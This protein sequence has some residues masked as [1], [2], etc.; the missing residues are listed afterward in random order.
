MRESE[1]EFAN[2]INKTAKMWPNEITRQT[3]LVSSPFAGSLDKEINFWKDLDRKLAETKD[4]MESAPILLTKL[5]L[6][7]TSRISEQLIIEAESKLDRSIETVRASLNFIRDFP[8]AELEEANSLAKINRSIS[9]CLSH[10]AKMRHSVYDFTRAMKMLEVLGSLIISRIVVIFQQKNLLVCSM[11]ELRILKGQFDQVLTTWKT[12]LT[13][14]KATLKD[15][16][17]RRNEKMPTL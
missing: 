6:K 4:Q 14:Q 7:R 13:T 15:V 10:F 12:Q 11:E 3:K 8:L 17:K 5:V 1:E 9:N 2:E 16:A